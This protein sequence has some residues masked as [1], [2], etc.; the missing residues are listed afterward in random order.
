MTENNVAFKSGDLTLEGVWSV[1]G[2]S[3]PFPA[4]VVC[5]PHPLY[6]GNMDNNVVSAVCEGLASVSIACLRFNFRGVGRSQG[7]HANGVGEKDDVRAA[8]AFVSSQN[9]GEGRSIG[10]CGYSFGAGVALEVAVNEDAVEA[11]ALISPIMA[12]PSPL[13]DYHRPKLVLWGSHDLALPGTDLPDL[14]ENLPEPREYE[15]VSGAD[16]FWW[17]H[18]QRIADRVSAFFKHS[19]R[20]DR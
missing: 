9:G 20:S 19:L 17:G 4:A 18:E 14:S 13:Q 12:S 5:H 2:G 8:L 16:H 6:G 1:P 10:L 11:L 3:G 15:I 7:S